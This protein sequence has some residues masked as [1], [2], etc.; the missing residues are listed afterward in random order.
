MITIIQQKDKMATI[1][2]LGC[3]I[4][5][6]MLLLDEKYRLDIEDFPERFHQILYGCIDNLVKQGVQDINSINIDDYLSK[7]PRQ[8]KV[9]EDNK[10]MEY[11]ENAVD[12]AQIENFDYYY[13][14][15]RKFGL[16]NQLQKKGFDTTI[17]YDP[18]V[19][20][21]DQ[22]AEM[23]KQFDRL[24]VQDIFTRY[25]LSISEL[26]E[27]YDSSSESTG[28]QA[29][30]G[31]M[32]LKEQY[33]EAPEMGMPFNSGVMTTIARGRR[34][35]KFYLKSA[36]S[37][38]GKALPNDSLIPTPNGWKRVGDIKVG[39]YLFGQDGKPTKVLNVFPQG[40]KQVWEVHFKD[41]R[42]VPCCEDHLWE[43]WYDSSEKKNG[44]RIE[45][46]KEIYERAL[47][48]NNGFRDYNGK[49][50]RFAV[51]L[52]CPVEY[53]TKELN[54]DPYV[55]GAL[56]GNG[57]F[58]YNKNQKNLTYSSG[59]SET[60]DRIASILGKN[61]FAKKNSLYNYNYTFKDKN[62][63]RHNLWVEEILKNYPQLWNKKSEN[64]FI[65]R[66][67]LEGDIKQRWA[68]LQGLMDTDGHTDSDKKGR[69]SYYTVSPRLRDDIIEL[70]RSLGMITSFH[71]DSREGR[72]D[73][74]IICIQC[75][76]L[77][78]RYVFRDSRKSEIAIQYSSSNKRFEKVE[79]LSIAS[80]NQTNNFS[81]MTCFVVDNE[82]H[83]FLA[84]DFIVTHNSRVSLGDAARVSIPYYYDTNTREWLNTGCSSPTLFITTELEVDEIQSLI[85]AYVSGVPEEHILDGNYKGDEENRVDKAIE[86]IGRSPL[87]IEQIPNFDIEDIENI[88]KKYK[89]KY[90]VGYVFFDYLFSSIKIMSEVAGKTKGVKLREDNVLLMFADRMKS[91]AN[92]LN[93]H[94]D[95]STQVNGEWRNAKEADMNL[96][97][98][99]K[100]V[101]D[102]VDL[103]MILLPVSEADKLG[104]E[105]IV[106]KIQGFLPQPNL[107]FHIYKNRR[108]KLNHVRLFVYFDYS[109]CRTTDLFVTD[110]KYN[111]IDVESTLV[112]FKR[113][114]EEDVDY[115]EEAVEEP[116]IETPEIL[117]E[118]QQQPSLDWF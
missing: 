59:S 89:I 47:N 105:T 112:D 79:K 45:T 74:Y 12:L 60:P 4:K 73:G 72:R 49:G 48:L 85:M 57:S 113:D 15:F 103:G 27:V 13:Q 114:Y 16:L 30:D 80:I 26:K 2:V 107:V 55:M 43:Y 65:P 93:V 9:F 99:S 46:T 42:V 84:N 37:G 68:L 63:P 28:V 117:E 11:V 83:L 54:P 14:T 67:Y 61:I 118:E 97:R 90:Q 50:Y 94:I 29:A 52:N 56:L 96:I 40:V 115:V 108:G 31:M 66:D 22:Q 77:W 110:N 5:Q 24:S 3:L 17:I 81:E 98:S 111:L 104:I 53:S 102:K 32:A 75:K 86:F 44:K 101:A 88:I 33:K 58:R 18:N 38:F 25:E 64:K 8:H 7:F 76:K 34:L 100:A 62:N 95:T 23:Q 6:P 21:V 10:G 69:L 78:K 71:V 20:D 35:K 41:G 92:I 51:K 19:I 106:A 116:V 70:C 109:T 82:D 87:F 36:P 91:L 1:Q 39:D